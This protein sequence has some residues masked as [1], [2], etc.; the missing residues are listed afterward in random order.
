MRVGST[1]LVTHDYHPSASPNLLEAKVTIQNTSDHDTDVRYR[2]VID[3]GVEPTPFDAFV[4][5]V[6]IQG[7]QRA[8]N[9]LFSSD[10]GFASANP[11][12][13]ASSILFA[14]DRVDSGPK[15]H[16]ALFDFGFGTLKPG[17]Q[18]TFNIYYGAAASEAEANAALGDV[19]AEVYSY[20]QPHCPSDACP[21]V[22][23]PRD[24]RPNTFVFAFSKVG[25]APV[26]P[27]D[28]TPTTSSTSST[29]TAP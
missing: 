17:E 7:T 16:G 5:V 13:V 18:V 24:G 12:A 28:T 29:T 23:G 27:P 14:G 22:N 26:L 1:F 25:G 10:D 6:T 15:H 4:S 2:R 9:V 21:A 19:Q 20:G 11:L 8:K 3:W